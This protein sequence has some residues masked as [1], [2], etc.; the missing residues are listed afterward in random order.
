[1]LPSCRW[2][3]SPSL[4]L[5]LGGRGTRR[6]ASGR[7][8]PGG[9][10]WGALGVARGGGREPRDESLGGWASPGSRPAPSPP[11]AARAARGCASSWYLPAP[12]TPP[13]RSSGDDHLK[14]VFSPILQ[15]LLV[16]A[17]WKGKEK[18][19]LRA[20]PFLD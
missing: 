17:N 5:P 6:A 2:P 10:R 12:S 8:G 11:A 9:D 14:R 16:V 4:R 15:R 7:M 18:K 1:M 19:T 13:R 20:H 3:R